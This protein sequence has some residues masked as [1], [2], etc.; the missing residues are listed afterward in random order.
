M[1]ITE[2]INSRRPASLMS[3]GKKTAIWLAIYINNLFWGPPRTSPLVWWWGPHHFEGNRSSRWPT[4]SNSGS[5]TCTSLSTGSDPHQYRGNYVSCTAPT[6]WLYM[7]VL[8]NESSLEGAGGW[9]LLRCVK[10]SLSTESDLDGGRCRHVLPQLRG[11][12]FT[13]QR[14]SHIKRSHKR[15]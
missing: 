12:L 7:R 14:W 2:T 6:L 8:K 4:V 3:T 5:I 10:D 1:Q 15:Y 13:L 9:N 11:N